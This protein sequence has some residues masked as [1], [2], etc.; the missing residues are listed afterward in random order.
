MAK[1]LSS[2]AKRW[3]GIGIR[4]EDDVVNRPV[5]VT[6]S[7]AVVVFTTL[8]MGCTVSTLAQIFFKNEMKEKDGHAL[9]D[10][11]EADDSNV[12]HHEKVLHPNMENAANKSHYRNPGCLRRFERNFLKPLLIYKYGEGEK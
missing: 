5:I 1:S 6:T 8:F 7:L 3:R 2:V 12:S 10:Q 9:L 11:K 4:I